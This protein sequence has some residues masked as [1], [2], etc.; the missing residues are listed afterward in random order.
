MRLNYL[1]ILDS[2]ELYEDTRRRMFD[3]NLD[4]S[5]IYMYIFFL[6]TFNWCTQN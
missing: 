6:R 4:T 3:T 5:F 2:N 1:T